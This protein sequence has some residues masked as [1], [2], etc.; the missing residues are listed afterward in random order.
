ME[1]IILIIAAIILFVAFIA[2][3]IAADE[4][5]GQ[6]RQVAMNQGNVEPDLDEAEKILFIAAILSLAGGI[7]ALLMSLISYSGIRKK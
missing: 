6:K 4:V 1:G 2:F 3:L 7:I 5:N